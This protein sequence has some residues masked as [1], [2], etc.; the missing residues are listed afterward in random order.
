MRAKE[1]RQ[2]RRAT[3]R[4]RLEQNMVG[5]VE[6]RH[7]LRVQVAGAQRAHPRVHH[8]AHARLIAFSSRAQQLVARGLH[9]LL[10][11]VECAQL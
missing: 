10:R 8:G 6:E 7:A 4:V 5:H 9:A 3:V 1:R 11:L 2:R